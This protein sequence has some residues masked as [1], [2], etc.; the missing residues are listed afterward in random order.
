MTQNMDYHGKYF[1]CTWNGDSSAGDGRFIYIC[2]HIMYVN[3]IKL[4][5]S[6]IQVFYIF[7][8]SLSILPS[9]IERGMM[10]LQQY[11]VFA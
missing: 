4:V 3:Y 8:D 7:D 11:C 5:I 9:V 10:N 6:V 1:V 2:I